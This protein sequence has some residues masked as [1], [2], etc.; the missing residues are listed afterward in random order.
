M[1][2][3]SNVVLYELTT[4]RKVT[5][6]APISRTPP[7]FQ[8]IL[9]FSGRPLIVYRPDC[10]RPRSDPIQ[11]LVRRETGHPAERAYLT[12]YYHLDKTGLAGSSTA[13]GTTSP[14]CCAASSGLSLS[15]QPITSIISNALPYTLQMAGD[16]DRPGDRCR[17]G[18]GVIAGIK[19]G[20][21]FDNINA[22]GHARRDR[23]C[24]CWVIGFLVQYFRGREVGA[25]AAKAYNFTFKA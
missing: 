6:D 2:L 1:D 8:M 9:A 15:G 5:R 10:S 22:G 12:A 25:P 7:Y 4:T 23:P 17:V 13:T 11:A 24:R 18:F 14:I 16:R 3:F 21:W 19:K 20:G